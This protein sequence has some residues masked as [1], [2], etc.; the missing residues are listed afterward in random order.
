[1]NSKGQ[2]VLKF[3]VF[4]IVSVT[5]LIFI[6]V[7]ANILF[8][9]QTV[10]GKPPIIFDVVVKPEYIPLLA[11]HSLYTLLSSTDE[12]TGK[13]VQELLAYSAFQGKTSIDISGKGKVDVEKIVDEKMK[14]ILPDKEYNLVIQGTS[15]N[16]GNNNLGITTNVPSPQSTTASTQ[17]Y[18]SKS[19]STIT[20]PNLK[21]VEVIL[22]IG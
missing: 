18:S 8:A 13:Q 2:T 17:T 6:F 12:G 15:I 19:V 11:D 7:L 20:L 9:Y 3:I 5:S 16:L 10:T 1:M 4:I 22:Y 14:F 21:K